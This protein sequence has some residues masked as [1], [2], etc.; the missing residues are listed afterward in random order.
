VPRRAIEGLKVPAFLAWAREHLEGHPLGPVASPTPT[1]GKRWPDVPGA[2][3]PEPKSCASKDAFDDAL[4]RWQAGE[5]Q[6]DGAPLSAKSGQD[7]VE[8]LAEL[9]TQGGVPDRGVTWVA[10]NVSKLFAEAG[11]CANDRQDF[12][13]AVTLL[14]RAVALGPMEFSPRLELA[15]AFAA[16]K[17]PD[18]A[19]PHLEVALRIAHNPCYLARAWRKMGF[20]RFDQGRFADAKEAYQNS[21]KYEPN[22]ALALGELKLI[23]EA[24]AKG[25]AQNPGAAAQYPQVPQITTHC[26]EPSPPVG[27]NPRI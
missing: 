16:L 5:A 6:I 2:D 15:H 25:G 23:N 14:E 19:V 12:P 7:F 27:G 11:F 1:N 4:A 18:Q 10:P 17:R 22:N 24:L 20:V 9:R 8:Q 21:L 26:S 13:L 3:L